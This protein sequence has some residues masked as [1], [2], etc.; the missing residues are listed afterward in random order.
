MP[1]IRRLT[2]ADAPAYRAIR[3]EALANA[4]EAFGS[5]LAREQTFSTADFAARLTNGAVF[6][7]FHQGEITG[8]AGFYPEPGEKDRH[9]GHLVGMYVQP[10]HRRT[11]TSRALV[12][13]VLTHATTEVEQ[14]HLN[15]ITENTQAIRLYQSCGFTPYGTEPRSLK[16]DGRYFDS[17]LMVHFL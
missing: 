8:I 9:K 13:A 3:L 2:P 11:G 6:A 17:L 10:A 5:T 16:Q 12:H 4:P 15:V 1:P 14:L 7:S